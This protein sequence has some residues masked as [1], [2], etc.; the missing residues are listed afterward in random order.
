MKE[1]KEAFCPSCGK[2]VAF[3]V[4]TAMEKVNVRGVEVTVPVQY[5]TCSECHE[6]LDVPS[7]SEENLRVAYEAY[8]KKMGLMS[9]DEIKALRAKYHISASALSLLIGAGEKTITRYENGAIQDTIYDM[10]LKLLEVPE[11]FEKLVELSQK[12][13]E[14][15]TLEKCADAL[16]KAVPTT[17]RDL[18]DAYALSVGKRFVASPTL[19]QPSDSWKSVPLAKSCLMDLEPGKGYQRLPTYVSSP[20]K[21][22]VVVYGE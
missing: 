8:K 22:G 13:P 20:S 17:T 12:K 7:I 5:C 4:E 19:S 3:N 15:K 14:G 21:K 10:V 9:G 11:I 16:H 2:N 18:L 1:V 6:E